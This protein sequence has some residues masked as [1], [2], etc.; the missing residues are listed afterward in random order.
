MLPIDSQIVFTLLFLLSLG[1][2]FLAHEAGH[3][4]MA[5]LLG[6]H[7][8][9]V[10]LGFGREV[11]GRTDKYGTRWS[12]KIFPF[13][14]MVQLTDPDRETPDDFARRPAWFRFFMV[15]AG[16]AASFFFAYV[17]FVGF[18]ALIGQPSTRPI[19]TAVQVASPA[20]RAGIVPGDQIIL[21]QGQPVE[22][23]ED[24]VHALRTPMDQDVTLRL[25]RDGAMTD[26]ALTPRWDEY[27]DLRGFDRAHGRLGTIAQHNPMDLS[28][29]RAVDGIATPTR[30]AAFDALKQHVGK[31][32][33]LDLF[34]TNGQAVPYRIYID[35]ETNADLMLDTMPDPAV[36]YMGRIRGDMYRLQTFE[37]AVITGWHDFARLA[38]GVFGTFRDVWPLDRT[39]IR[40]ETQVIGDGL[41][42]VA[43]VHGVLFMMALLS[44]MIGLLNLIPLPGLDG[45]WILRYAMEAITG[46]ETTRTF[47]PYLW[48]VMIFGMVLAWLLANLDGLHHIFPAPTILP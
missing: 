19:V 7:V 1:V 25:M 9:R 44:I 22:R 34:S 18:Y 2:V 36:L 35:P 20:D 43:G 31:T 23:Y 11:W 33:V 28:A 5:R 16:P 42:L 41:R 39:T 27:T 29:V 48:R 15:L 4:L 12:I 47:Y 24:I 21:F 46:V 17:L 6:V 3:L 10:S 32:V 26:I 37:Q 14:G 13:S 45:Y 8:T 38:R 30:Q 40:P